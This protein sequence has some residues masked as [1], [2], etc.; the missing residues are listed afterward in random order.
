[1]LAIRENT[2]ADS[3]TVRFSS[4]SGQGADRLSFPIQIALIGK[5]SDEWRIAQPLLVS[6]EQDENSF[7]ASDDIFSMFGLGD[8]L[9]DALIDYVSVLTEYYQVL[10]SHNDDPS[11]ALFRRLRSYLQPI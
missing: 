2:T 4:G 10:S 3:T 5:L 1:M 9:T 7:I 6:I 8:S 11:A